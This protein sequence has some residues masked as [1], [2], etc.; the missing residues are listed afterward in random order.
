MVDRNIRNNTRT[1]RENC[2]EPIAINGGGRVIGDNVV[3]A[4]EL[5]TKAD[6][7]SNSSQIFWLGLRL[8]RV[9]STCLK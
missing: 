3:S 6:D 4:A 5:R 1:T 8:T 7:L 2:V 9:G